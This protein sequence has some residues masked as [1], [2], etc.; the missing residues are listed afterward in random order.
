MDVRQG[1]SSFTVAKCKDSTLRLTPLFF[2]VFL[3]SC[4][5]VRNKYL[6][7]S[8]PCQVLTF[9]LGP[10][11]KF[12]NI[13]KALSSPKIVSLNQF[14]KVLL[15]YFNTLSLVIFRLPSLTKALWRTM[16]D[17]TS[18]LLFNIYKW[19]C[20]NSSR[21]GVITCS[22]LEPLPLI[23]LS[24]WDSRSPTSFAFSMYSEQNYYSKE[25]LSS[26]LCSPNKWGHSEE[27]T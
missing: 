27:Y 5:L 16:Y 9:H 24:C 17:I 11:T 25:D 2:T 19:A 8:Y 22:P 14:R 12:L 3:S 23:L 10:S 13:S 1:L 20:F 6:L 26:K 7:I 21:L 18:L 15:C 4:D